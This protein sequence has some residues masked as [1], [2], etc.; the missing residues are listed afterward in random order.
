MSP[1]GLP[2]RE[3]NFSWCRR[4]RGNSSSRSTV[5]TI[6]MYGAGPHTKAS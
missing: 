2:P 5:V 6:F 3:T 4:S 1:N